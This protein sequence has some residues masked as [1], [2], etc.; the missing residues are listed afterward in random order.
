MTKVK[1]SK[2]KTAPVAVAATALLAPPIEPVDKPVVPRDEKGRFPVGVSGNPAGRAKGAKNRITL[3]R[4]ILEEGLR[5]QL[6]KAGPDIMRKALKMALEGDDK[7]MRVLLDKMLATPRGDD[8]AE[9]RDPEMTVNIHN[10]TSGAP[11]AVK[12]E[13]Q[14]VHLKIPHEK[15]GLRPSEL[16]HE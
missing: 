15:P 4:L 8:A 7:I 11:A 14:H 6:T 1:T 12:V 2:A 9:A 10:L 5:Q 3:A 16:S 13:A